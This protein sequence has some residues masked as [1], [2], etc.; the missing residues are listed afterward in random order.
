VRK[1][2]RKRFR[3]EIHARLASDETLSQKQI[4][5]AKKLIDGRDP[6]A[7][8]AVLL[9]AAQPRPAREPMDVREPSEQLDTRRGPASGAGRPGFVRFEINWGERGGA[10]PNRIL[11]HVCR[12]GDIRGNLIGAIEIGPET[13]TFDV[14]ES[15]ASLFEKRVRRPDPRDPKLRI[16]RVGG[17][18]R[19]SPARRRS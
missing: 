2:L 12:R 8:V 13:S 11:G 16:V 10:A 7:V 19:R 6:A 5:Y 17:A 4:D 3:Q 15:A 1:Q 18:P 9:E 14:T